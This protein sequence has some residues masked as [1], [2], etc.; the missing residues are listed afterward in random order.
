MP[1]SLEFVNLV[2]NFH[3]LDELYQTGHASYIVKINKPILTMEIM[4]LTIS[5]GE[6]QN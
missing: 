6:W 3:E 4:F 2:T 1:W 5:E